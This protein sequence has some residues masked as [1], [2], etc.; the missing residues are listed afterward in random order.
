MVPQL[1]GPIDFVFS[2]A[3]KGWYTN[4]FKDLEQKL[5]VGGCYVSHNI[6]QRRRQTGITEYV[7][8]IESLSNFKTTYNNDGGG[9]SIS[10]KTSE[11]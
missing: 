4:Y 11:N 7:N 8:Y 5:D 6:S 1:K 9:V 2:D 3:D 10:Y